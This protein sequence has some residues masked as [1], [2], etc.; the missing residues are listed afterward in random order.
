MTRQI[1]LRDSGVDSLSEVVLLS[2]TDGV[3]DSL[4][5]HHK[6]RG[7]VSRNKTLLKLQRQGFKLWIKAIFFSVAC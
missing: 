5:G 3:I 7:E 1:D 4:V 6:A 2:K